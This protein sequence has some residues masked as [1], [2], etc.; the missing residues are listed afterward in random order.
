MKKRPFG[1]FLELRDNK[2]NRAMEDHES[3]GK[4]MKATISATTAHGYELL[5]PRLASHDGNKCLLKA[6]RCTKKAL[7]CLVHGIHPKTV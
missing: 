6:I 5:R 4:G 2:S 1:K 3:N 7:F